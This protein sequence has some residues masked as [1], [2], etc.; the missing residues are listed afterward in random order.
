MK[1]NFLIQRESSF[2]EMGK[3][4]QPIRSKTAEN[5]NAVHAKTF[6]FTCN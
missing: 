5:T 6:T 2:K 4:D 1:V 3:D